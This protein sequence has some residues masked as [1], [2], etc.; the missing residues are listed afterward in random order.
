MI[1]FVTGDELSQTAYYDVMRR[2]F[3][4]RYD[5]G[6]D[7]W[8]E[9]PA[10]GQAAGILCAALGEHRAR[11]LDV[12]AGRGRDTAALLRAGHQVTGIDIV[13]MP[14][15]DR[16]AGE[17]GQNVR[18]ECA[19]LLDLPPVPAYD[20]VLD[21]GCLHHQ[22]P[23]AYDA[24]LRR[25]HDVLRADGLLTV[26]VY[27]ARAE[28]GALYRNNDERLH[29]DFTEPELRE[30]LSAAGFAVVGVREVPR[31][32]NNLRYLIVTLRREGS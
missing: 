12:G 25:L 30:L 23:E 8:T 14:E 11:V 20:A 29:R 24:Y 5:Q 6:R 28:A 32:L 2:T 4:D 9:E 16:I 19:G 18:F 26:S 7:P 17:W 13:A 3:A 27:L 10:M 21:N 22:H 15:W 1:E 31:T